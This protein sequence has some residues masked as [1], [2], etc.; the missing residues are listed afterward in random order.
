T[1]ERV[2][3]ELPT[4][5]I[6]K[7]PDFVPQIVELLRSAERSITIHC[8]APAYCIIS[9]YGNFDKYS[10]IIRDKLASSL[11][12]RMICLNKQAREKVNRIQFHDWN[13]WITGGDRTRQ[14]QDFVDRHFPG[15]GP[16]PQLSLDQFIPLLERTD[17][18][19][20]AQ[21]FYRAE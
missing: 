2:A 1:L 5:T 19:V 4:R 8:D 17:Q 6:G 18:E 12:V 10:G 9:D 13:G 16:V 3:N 14:V 11:S 21:T 7:F 20:L 15:C